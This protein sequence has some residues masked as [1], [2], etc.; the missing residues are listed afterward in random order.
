[1]TTANCWRDPEVAVVDIAVPPD[2]Q[3]QVVKDIV[4][5][6]DHIRGVCWLRSR[7]E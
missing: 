5:H 3:L 7:W 4:E 2:V 1:M 6:F